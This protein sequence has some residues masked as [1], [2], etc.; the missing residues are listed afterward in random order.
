MELV[1]YPKIQQFRNIVKA[2]RTKHNFKGVD[3]ETGEA[4]FSHDTPYPVLNFQGTV[5]LHGS[6]AAIGI[7]KNGEIWVQSRNRVLTVEDDNLRF[8]DFVYSLPEEIIDIL[9]LNNI[10]IYGEWC[11]KGIQK[12][13]A[14]SGL[15]KMFVIF[16]VKNLENEKW[17][18]YD[19]MNDINRKFASKNQSQLDFLNEYNIYFIDQFVTE[20]EEVDFNNPELAQNNLV[21]LTKKVGNECPVGKYFGVSGIGEGIVWK[22]IDEGFESSD[23]LNL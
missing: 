18:E 23:L 19:F 15:D 9:K 8:A 16:S 22:C 11:G 3:E 21:E 5:K 1:K 17:I 10:V 20:L 4:I 6:N 13:V 12:G 7:N 14:I 2:V